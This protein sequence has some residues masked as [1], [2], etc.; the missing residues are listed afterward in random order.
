MLVLGIT[1]WF[2]RDRTAQTVVVVNSESKH[3]LFSLALLS[4]FCS[5][6]K[7]RSDGKESDFQEQGAQHAVVPLHR[8]KPTAFIE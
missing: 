8:L 2:A 4:G 1:H 3:G 6:I 7:E 5:L